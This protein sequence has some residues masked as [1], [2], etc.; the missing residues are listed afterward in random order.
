[1]ASSQCCRQCAN[2]AKND[3]SWKSRSRV[4]M[5]EIAQD[6][7]ITMVKV[8]NRIFVLL[9]TMLDP[10]YRAIS[11]EMTWFYSTSWWNTGKPWNLHCH[12]ARS[13]TIIPHRASWSPGSIT[14]LCWRRFDLI[15]AWNH[16]CY[17]LPPA[18]F[19]LLRMVLALS[20][21]RFLH[22]GV[23]PPLSLQLIQAKMTTH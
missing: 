16:H 13:F 9:Q 20:L 21:P 8:V 23:S 2:V 5:R 3:N 10:Q 14:G 12:P 15:S 4:D 18:L 22:S 7:K 17:N 1:M 6:L 11:Q 19:L